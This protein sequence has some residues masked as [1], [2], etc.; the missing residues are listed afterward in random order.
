[1]HK[2]RLYISAVIG[3]ICAGLCVTFL[4][5]RAAAG[6]FKRDAGRL[7]QLRKVYVEAKAE[8]KKLEYHELRSGSFLPPSTVAT[9]KTQLVGDSRLSELQIQKAVEA[10]TYF[11]QGMSAPS[12]SEYLKF[13]LP[14]HEYIPRAE[15][16]KFL[17][18]NLYK[19]PNLRKTGRQLDPTDSELFEDL[20]NYSNPSPYISRVAL[21][22]IR[23]SLVE[24]TSYF[25]P[26]ETLI[27][28]KNVKIIGYASYFPYFLFPDQPDGK[29]NRREGKFLVFVCIVDS[30]APDGLVPLAYKCY[31]S[32]RYSMWLPHGILV[33]T[34]FNRK[35]APVF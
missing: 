22:S 4:L 27:A 10:L 30:R 32:E 29:I 33:G 7:A 11:F 18:A 8:W 13:R 23:V 28:D 1:V 9:V 24:N 34:A 5:K 17:R 26:D 3:V 14:I 20:W 2:G 12:Y 31:W 35:S 19:T 21:N 25:S 6:S 16:A 15:A